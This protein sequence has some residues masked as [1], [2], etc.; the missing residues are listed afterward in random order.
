MVL[1][2]STTVTET[3]ISIPMQIIGGGTTVT[4]YVGYGGRDVIAIVELLKYPEGLGEPDAAPDA[5]P[6]VGGYGTVLLAG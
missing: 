1:H 6:V 3:I 4:E 5:L 2:D